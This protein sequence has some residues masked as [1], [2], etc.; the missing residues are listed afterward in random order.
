V[1]SRR[2][3]QQ[4]QQTPH[5]GVKRSRERLGLRLRHLLRL[6]EYVLRAEGVA[7]EE[8]LKAPTRL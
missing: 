1:S 5:A 8:A 6:E 7:V 2:T 4:E 3:E